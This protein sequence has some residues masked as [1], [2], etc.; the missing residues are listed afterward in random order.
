MAAVLRAADAGCQPGEHGPH[1]VTKLYYIAWNS[2]MWEAYQAAFGS[3]RI[4][5]D[6]VERRPVPYPDWAVTTVLDTAL[7]TDTVWKAVQCHRSQVS[8]GPGPAAWGEHRRRVLWGEQHLYR[9]MSLVD[10]RRGIETDL[11]EGI[12]E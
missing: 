11:F 6:S 12:R 5:V 4:V 10:C 8:R 7:H 1:V 3:V 9:A 2:W